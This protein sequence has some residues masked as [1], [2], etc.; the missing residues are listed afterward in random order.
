MF[1]MKKSFLQLFGLLWLFLYVTTSS[2]HAASSLDCTQ[3]T[4]INVPVYEC[5]A[6]MDFYNATNWDSW[7]KNN[8]RNTDTNVCSWFGVS[9]INI[10][11]ENRINGLSLPSNNLNGILPDSLWALDQLQNFVVNNNSLYGE[12]SDSLW[13]WTRISVFNISNNGFYGY[14]PSSWIL[15]WRISKFPFD[16]SYN[17]L[18]ANGYDSKLQETLKKGFLVEPQNVCEGFDMFISKSVL[19]QV[20]V[21]PEDIIWYNIF[22]QNRGSLPAYNV[23]ITDIP[24]HALSLLE[25]DARYSIQTIDDVDTF[26]FNVWTVGVWEYGEIILTGQ[27]AE[28]GFLEDQDTI[29]N[30]VI[31]ESAN[32]ETNTN[33]TNNASAIS[34]LFKPFAPS[35][36]DFGWWVS[37][38]SSNGGT[39]SS[40]W[41][42]QNPISTWSQ[43]S[44]TTSWNLMTWANTTPSEENVTEESHN[45]CPYWDEKYSIFDIK[46]LPD[47]KSKIEAI[48]F[49]LDRC[50]I[51]WQYAEWK[52]FAAYDKITYG[53][54]YKMVVRSLWLPFQSTEW[55]WA[56][57]Y[58]SSASEK[59]LLDG[60][61]EGYT[62]DD[63]ASKDDVIIVLNNMLSFVWKEKSLSN[64]TVSPGIVRRWNFAVLLHSLIK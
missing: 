52:Y 40:S 62:L 7:V 12:L 47:N 39:T 18:V 16:F 4:N 46:D 14:I 19:K 28:T 43:V 45:L 24:G 61:V 36:T 8:W 10:A 22:Y 11:K 64:N 17:C 37:W 32:K 55:H 15:K 41:G 6:L 9:C 27:V 33:F 5:Q 29:I 26:V 53:E 30:N 50:I 31:I 56:L 20:I 57:W 34:A 13:T 54:L 63:F 48:K 59:G 21:Y 25:A 38:P 58:Q 60:V 35:T 1:S 2:T 44:D 42:V 3:A 23:K 51:Q 49:L